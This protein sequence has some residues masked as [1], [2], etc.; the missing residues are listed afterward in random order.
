MLSNFGPSCKAARAAISV[1]PVPLAHIRVAAATQP[2][3]AKVR[4]RK[5]FGVSAGALSIALLAATAVVRVTGTHIYVQ[6]SGTMALQFAQKLHVQVFI[7]PTALEVRSAAVSADFPVQLPTGLPARS[8]LRRLVYVNH[9]TIMLQYELPGA[10]RRKDNRLWIVLTN[11]AAMVGPRDE[12]LAGHLVPFDSEFGPNAKLQERW[13]I[14]GETVIITQ[15]KALPGE[16]AT[17]KRSMLAQL[18]PRKHLRTVL[19][20]E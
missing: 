4:T 12:N 2:R 3:A 14:G 8:Q 17:I 9:S 5:I 11:P 7:N 16:L 1:S 18:A 13:T 10:W 19:S 20:Q 15:S 6:P